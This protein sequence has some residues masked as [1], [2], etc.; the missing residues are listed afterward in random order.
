MSTLAVLTGIFICACTL[1]ANDVWLTTL[2][3]ELLI[4]GL[5]MEDGIDIKH[6]YVHILHLY[7]NVS[8]N[9]SKYMFVRKK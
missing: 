8:H 4:L 5:E 2:P 9:A 7:C 1:W 3:D 6:I